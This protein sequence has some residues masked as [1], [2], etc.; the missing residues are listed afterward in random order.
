MAA[1]GWHPAKPLHLEQARVLLLDRE[2]ERE[3]EM[4]NNMSRNEIQE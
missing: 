3:R 2:R 4:A 1:E